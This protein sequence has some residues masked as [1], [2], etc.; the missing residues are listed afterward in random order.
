MKRTNDDRKEKEVKG[1][2]ECYLDRNDPTRGNVS[3]IWINCTI[4]IRY[5]QWFT[6]LLRLMDPWNRM[7]GTLSSFISLRSLI[8]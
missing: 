5:S 7:P 1:T 2:L 3:I 4:R 8:I 6:F